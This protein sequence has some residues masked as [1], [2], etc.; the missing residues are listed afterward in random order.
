MYHGSPAD[1]ER[2]KPNRDNYMIDRAIGSHFSASPE[3]ADKMS[4]GL[5]RKDVDGTVYVAKAPK[6]SELIRVPQK[7]YR[8][9]HYTSKQMDQWAISS[10]VS[11][12]VLSKNRGMF[13][14]WIKNSRKIPDEMAHEI[15]DHL[16]AR[17]AP[18]HEKFGTAKTTATSFRSYLNNFGA[19]VEEPYP[20]FK[21]KIVD[22]FLDDMKSRGIKGMEY[23]NTSPQETAGMDKKRSRKSYVIFHPEEIPLSKLGK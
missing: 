9:P 2:L 14:D 19:T 5:Y 12:H 20:G 16:S 3:I 17:K 1:F 13:V 4:K 11:G 15:Y 7:T 8:N 10:F 6:R 23:I 21:R 18:S 22:T